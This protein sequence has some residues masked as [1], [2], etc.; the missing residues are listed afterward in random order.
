MSLSSRSIG[1]AT[2]ALLALED[3][4]HALGL[5]DLALHFWVI[6]LLPHKPA[7]SSSGFSPPTSTF[8]GRQVTEILFNGWL[9]LLQDC[10]QIA[11]KDNSFIRAGQP[12][13]HIEVSCDGMDMGLPVKDKP[14]PVDAKVKIIDLGS[15]YPSIPSRVNSK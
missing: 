6:M 3:Q 7:T 8:S 2:L 9:K 14:V 5:S 10:Y 13:Q 15:N 12:F 4:V 1:Y 11:K